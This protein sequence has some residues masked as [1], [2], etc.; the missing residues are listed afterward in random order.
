MLSALERGPASPIPCPRPPSYSAPRWLK[1]LVLFPFSGPSPTRQF[2]QGRLGRCPKPVR[3][4]TIHPVH[5]HGHR[6]D[7]ACGISSTETC[8]AFVSQEVPLHFSVRTP[9]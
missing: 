5:Q 9:S 8:S 6:Q 1:P 2:N 4:L 7:F 3:T